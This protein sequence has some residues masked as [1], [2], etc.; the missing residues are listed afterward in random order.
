MTNDFDLS[1]YVITEDLENTGGGFSLFPAGI[2]EGTIAG[3]EVRDSRAGGKFINLSVK[4]DNKRMVFDNINFICKSEKAQEIARKN[5]GRIGNANE[6]TVRK[7]GD[8]PGLRVNVTIDVEPAKGQ[9]PAKNVIRAYNPLGT[10]GE[11]SSEPASY[12][13]GGKFSAAAASNYEEDTPF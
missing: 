9:Y 7:A 3:A 5:L 6:C 12:V 8:L 1:D 11:V 2:Y 13:G 4:L 10:K